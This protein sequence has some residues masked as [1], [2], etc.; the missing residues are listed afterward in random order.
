M[1]PALAI[2]GFVAAVLALAIALGVSIKASENEQQVAVLWERVLVLEAL[3]DP[4]A[5]DAF[6]RSQGSR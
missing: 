4:Y 2:V 1:I 6:R 5:E 3:I